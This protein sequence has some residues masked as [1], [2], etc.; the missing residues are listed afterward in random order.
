VGGENRVLTTEVGVVA[1]VVVSEGLYIA[2]CV[3]FAPR[4]VRGDLATTLPL[5]DS[6]LKQ[7]ALL[8]VYREAGDCR[9]T[10]VVV[11]HVFNVA[12]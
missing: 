5:G 11:S 9:P 3:T 6:F 8:T 7:L 12:K 1:N 4:H 10:H 2:F